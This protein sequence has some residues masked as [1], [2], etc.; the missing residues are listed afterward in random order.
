M[1]SKLL[2]AIKAAPDAG[3]LLIRAEDWAKLA[4]ENVPYIP[5]NGSPPTILREIEDATGIYRA[6][7]GSSESGQPTMC[8]SCGAP[9]DDGPKCS[10][11]GTPSD[12]VRVRYGVSCLRPGMLAKLD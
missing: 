2:A 6:T 12:R 11:C 4:W 7:L 3:K 9:H 1:M 8:K 5:F 10:Y